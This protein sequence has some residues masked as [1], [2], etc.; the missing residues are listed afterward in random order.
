M[1]KPATRAFVTDLH[2]YLHEEASDQGLPDVDVVVATAEVGAGASQVEP[3]HDAR[4]LLSHVV[5]TLQWPIVDE[6]VI[7]PLRVIVICSNGQRLV[8]IV[9]DGSQL[10]RFSCKSYGILIN[11]QAYGCSRQSLWIFTFWKTNNFTCVLANFLVHFSKWISPSSLQN[12]SRKHNRHYWACT[13]H[14]F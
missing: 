2:N 8:G 3:V 10:V 5:R 11:W 13:V 1:K 12:V 9:V 4:Q 7:R 6:V 14:A